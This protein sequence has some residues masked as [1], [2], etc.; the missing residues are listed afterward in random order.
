MADAATLQ[1]RLD[2]LETAEFELVAGKKSIR[3]SYQGESVDYAATDINQIRNM[4]RS[5]KRQLGDNSA[6]RPQARGIV[7]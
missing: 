5:L 4:I 6:R 2:A 1:A 3:L 7:T